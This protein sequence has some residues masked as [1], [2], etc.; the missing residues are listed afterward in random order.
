[1]GGN[2]SGS[3][4]FFLGNYRLPV[5]DVRVRTFDPKNPE[6]AGAGYVNQIPEVTAWGRKNGCFMSHSILVAGQEPKWPPFEVH[7]KDVPF[8]AVL[9]EVAR[10]SGEYFW[11]LVQDVEKP[12]D[13]DVGF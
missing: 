11:S 7:V 1:V 12:C 2:L 3:V 10:E 9:D 4:R 8:S 5:L 6:W 13:I